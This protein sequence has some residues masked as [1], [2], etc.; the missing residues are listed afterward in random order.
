MFLIYIDLRRSIENSDSSQV[1]NL[2]LENNHADEFPILFIDRLSYIQGAILESPV[3]MYL[4]KYVH[5]FHIGKYC[6]LAN[7][8]KFVINLDHDYLKVNSGFLD[9]N[10]LSY[11]NSCDFKIRK[12]GQ[13]IIQNDVWIGRGATILSGVTIHNGSVI[14]AESVVAKDVPPYSIVV[15]NPARVIKYRFSEDI[16]EKLLSIRWWDWPVEKINEN[17]HKFEL[18]VEEFVDEFF[19][20]NGY[21]NYLEKLGYKSNRKVHN[22]ER[23][24]YVPDAEYKF[25]TWENVVGEFYLRYSGRIDKELVIFILGDPNYL[26][27]FKNVEELNNLVS[28]SKNIK[29]IFGNKC[30]LEN[31]FL[32]SDYYITNRSFETVNYTCLA[33][34]YKTKIISGV[35]CPIFKE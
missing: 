20:K 21:D 9:S 13:I 17:K 26:M 30:D 7:D 27:N 19:D 35:D 4:N 29:F 5:N 22:F 3:T 16:I 14:G 15:G 18:P 33:D 32:N 23:Y 31:C 24:L 28:L 34:Y 8:L 12:K 10:I 6:S 11:L 1:M 2:N 25:S